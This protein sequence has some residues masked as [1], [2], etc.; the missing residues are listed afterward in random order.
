M[1]LCPWWCHACRRALLQHPAGTHAV[2][3]WHCCPELWVPHPGGAQGHGWD[4]GSLRWW[5]VSQHPSI[6]LAT[7]THPGQGSP[8]QA[9][10]VVQIHSAA[11]NALQCSG[12][13]SA[14]ELLPFLVSFLDCFSSMNRIFII[15]FLSP[16]HAFSSGS[17]A[18]DRCL[19]MF[20]LKE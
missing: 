11:S 18:H 10:A 9:A 8:A 6:E 14:S 2:R 1:S 12:G 15:I 7:S 3:C 16:S 20:F 4:P 13:G 17:E 5:E 19:L